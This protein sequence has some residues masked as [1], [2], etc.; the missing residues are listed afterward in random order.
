MGKNYANRLISGSQ[1]AT[2]LVPMG[3]LCTPCEIQPIHENQVRPL[4]ILEPAQQCEVWE[5][6]VR[7]A[8]GKVV[9]YHVKDTVKELTAPAAEPNHLCFSLGIPAPAA[10]AFYPL[11]SFWGAPLR[12]EV[13]LVALSGVDLASRGEVFRGAS[14]GPHRWSRSEAVRARTGRD[15]SPSS[16]PSARNFPGGF[17]SQTLFARV[18]IYER[19][20]NISGRAYSGKQCAAS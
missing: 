9:T 16:F 20:G 18:P 19:Y 17:P 12:D 2:N 8:D 10:G 1:V 11:R 15:A 5:E 6:A 7:S 4:R 13:G 3:T 14:R